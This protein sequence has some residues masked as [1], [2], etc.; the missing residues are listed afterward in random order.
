LQGSA[1]EKPDTV[2]TAEPELHFLR[3]KAKITQETGRTE[4]VVDSRLGNQKG[5]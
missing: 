5:G 2:L 3:A 1:R 4:G